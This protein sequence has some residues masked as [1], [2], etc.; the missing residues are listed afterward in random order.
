MA[1]PVGCTGGIACEPP[2]YPHSRPKWQRAAIAAWS[3][4]HK[5]RLEERWMREQFG[6]AY[7]AYCRRVAALVPFVL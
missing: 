4:R 1:A 6:E 7:E 5:L 3:F 2:K